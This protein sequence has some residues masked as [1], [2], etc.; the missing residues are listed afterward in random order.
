[1]APPAKKSEDIVAYRLDELKSEVKDLSAKFDKL[2]NI[3]KSDLKDF[4]EVI[5]TRF[6]DMRS[7][8]QKQIDQKADQGELA[9]LKKLFYAAIG[10]LSSIIG[11]LV[12]G[13][14]TTRN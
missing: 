1:V 13:Y 3:K 11:A 6:L 12:I 9:D 14:L 7:D 2:D 4:Q 8:M 10:F 5:V